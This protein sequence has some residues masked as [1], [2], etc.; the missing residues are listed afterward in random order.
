MAIQDNSSSSLKYDILPDHGWVLE[1]KK[2]VSLGR[3]F[4]NAQFYTRTHTMKAGTGRRLGL[5][6]NS[7]VVGTSGLFSFVWLVPCNCTGA[8]DDKLLYFFFCCSQV[9][10]WNQG[11]IFF[12]FLYTGCVKHAWALHFIRLALSNA[13]G[14]WHSLQPIAYKNRLFERHVRIMYRIW[15]KVHTWNASLTILPRHIWNEQS[16][17]SPNRLTVQS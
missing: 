10:V 3:S 1:K 15:H 17:F 6:S 4:K 2:H 16:S 9:F 11:V 13:P 14:R 12:F 7:L 5:S 8:A